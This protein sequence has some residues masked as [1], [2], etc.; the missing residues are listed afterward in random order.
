[1][2]AAPVQVPINNHLPPQQLQH[3]PDMV[4]GIGLFRQLN[5][6]Q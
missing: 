6:N 4:Q 3:P 5:A 1:M 2:I